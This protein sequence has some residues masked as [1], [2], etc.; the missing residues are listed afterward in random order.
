VAA[1]ENRAYYMDE[2][3]EMIAYIDTLKAG[4]CLSEKAIRE[5]YEVFKT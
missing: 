4:E 5:G 2:R 3:D 1:A